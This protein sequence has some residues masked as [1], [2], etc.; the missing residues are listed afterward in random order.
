MNNWTVCKYPNECVCTIAGNGKCY[1]GKI[2]RKTLKESK[3]SSAMPSSLSLTEI[4]V[5]LNSEVIHYLDL[6][7]V[8]LVHRALQVA[9][10]DKGSNF[11]VLQWD[12]YQGYNVL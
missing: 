1:H 7:R 9:M 12:A 2:K 11:A 3:S 10:D 6:K 5:R 8:P 4:C